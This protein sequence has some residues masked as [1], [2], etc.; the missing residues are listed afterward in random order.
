MVTM[1]LF[2]GFGQG[3]FLFG[4]NALAIC[5]RLLCTASVFKASGN[6]IAI[7]ACS[8]TKWNILWN[9]ALAARRGEF[10]LFLCND[11][12]FVTRSYKLLPPLFLETSE[13]SIDHSIWRKGTF[14]IDSPVTSFSN[15]TWLIF[16]KHKK[17]S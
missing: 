9:G 14:T 8:A 3:A 7:N 10:F 11:N 13:R 5:K 16:R 6:D 12:G 17:L 15:S 1:P 4:W 2:R